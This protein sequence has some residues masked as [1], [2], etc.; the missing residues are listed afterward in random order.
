QQGGQIILDGGDNGAVM[1]AS[2]LDASGRD[3][4][5]TGGTVNVLGNNVQLAS[6]A[7]V[8]VSGDAGG[9]TALIG[10]NFHRAGP[11]RNAA[12][13]TVASG[14]KLLADAVT[15]G[16]GGNVAIW[17]NQST[18]VDG[19]ISAKGGAQGGNG[20]RVETSGATLLV[21]ADASVNMS[22]PAGLGG[23]WDI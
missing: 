13:T 14:P 7:V 12:K 17:S 6:T 15:S 3:A 4:G 9:G 16:N 18:T 2:T 8:D 21:S 5:Q 10:G 22:A 19:A 20:G 23:S 11:Q 1:V